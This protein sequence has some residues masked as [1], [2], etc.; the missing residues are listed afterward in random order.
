MSSQ[1]GKVS[2]GRYRRPL[3]LRNPISSLIN[4]GRTIALRAEKYFEELI[5]SNCP[6][7]PRSYALE[8]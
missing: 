2:I 8:K 7:D 6:Y 1:F 3:S 4:F 5:T